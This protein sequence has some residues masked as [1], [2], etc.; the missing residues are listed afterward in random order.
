MAATSSGFES[1][2]TLFHDSDGEETIG[3]K[4]KRFFLP[5]GPSHSSA[6][7]T[8]GSATPSTTTATPA[9]A[10]LPAAD[11]PSAPSLPVPIDLLPSAAKSRQHSRNNSA[12]QQQLAQLA[13]VGAP[14]QQATTTSTFSSP[15]EPVKPL[16]SH[17]TCATGRKHG[18]P[19]RLSGVSP[20][21]R[22]TVANSERGDLIQS[23]SSRSI[24]GDSRYG[25]D[26]IG[27]PG[28]GSHGSPTAN[29]GFALGNLSSIPGFPLGREGGDDT[30]SVRSMSTV[31]RPSPSAAHVFRKLRG[32]VSRRQK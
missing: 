10:A 20:S 31:A 16:P 4:I 7:S 24:H 29:D 30:K 19:I 15:S 1:F 21:V 5:T 32:E 28:G 6:S 25:S 22:V 9:A 27:T 23:A 14:S 26:L 2:P 12:T 17:P 13:A 11:A 18:R 8:A 3:S